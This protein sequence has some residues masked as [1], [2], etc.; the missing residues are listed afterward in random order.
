MAG[1]K[2][3]Y[4]QA[5]MFTSE[6][7]TEKVD[8]TKAKGKEGLSME[9]VVRNGKAISRTTRLFSLSSLKRN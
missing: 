2:R 3:Y 8:K 6:Y 5:Q 1:R 9:F 4:G 7:T